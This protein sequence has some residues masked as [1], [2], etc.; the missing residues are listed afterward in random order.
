MDRSECRQLHRHLEELV[1]GSL[2]GEVRPDLERHLER[3]PACRRLV[4]SCRRNARALAVLARRPAPEGGLER[5]W[6]EALDREE[7]SPEGLG[8]RLAGLS[9][10]PAPAVDLTD[11]LLARG[12]GALSPKN[13]PAALDRAV[14]GALGDFIRGR[15]RTGRVLRL[16]VGGMAA[17]ASL[18]LCLSLWLRTQEPPRAQ[19]PHFVYR[20]VPAPLAGWGAFE[21]DR[22]VDPAKGRER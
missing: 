16:V 15:S 9:R 13:A 3:C 11:P 20:D 8:S 2:P 18:L 19:G 5:I 6:E 21:A 1:D 4:E 7:R 14:Y 17:A 12:F 22:T 10:R